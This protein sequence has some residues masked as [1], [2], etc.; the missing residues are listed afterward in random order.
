[1]AP[2][3][4][5]PAPL[6]SVSPFNC[7]SPFLFPESFSVK[8]WKPKK[9]PSPTKASEQPCQGK[10]GYTT[11]GGVPETPRLLSTLPGAPAWGIAL[12]DVGGAWGG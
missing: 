10:G 5:D 4:Q 6:G 2:E 9:K 12:Q 8:E 7:S 11:R 3:G 1:M